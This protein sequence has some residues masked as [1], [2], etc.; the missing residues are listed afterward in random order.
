MD[1]FMRASAAPLETQTIQIE[2]L[3]ADD[4][5]TAAALIA[6]ERS[7]REHAERFSPPIRAG[8]VGVVHQRSRFA[9]QLQLSRKEKYDRTTIR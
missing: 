9:A 4:G 5:A 8:P 2:D 6:L 3:H 1:I 7:D